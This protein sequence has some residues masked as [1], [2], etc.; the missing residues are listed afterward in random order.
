MAHGA[1]QPTGRPAVVALRGKG[2]P[3]VNSRG[4]Q[5]PSR[6]RDRRR[7]AV[8]GMSKEPA[9][10]RA[11]R[12]PDAPVIEP[13]L[14]WPGLTLDRDGVG[15]PWLRHLPVA[16]SDLADVPELSGTA[17]RGGVAAVAGQPGPR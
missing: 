13:A 8:T 16:R 3:R 4:R 1:G 12:P 7:P 9:G 10:R 6:G 15:L 17:A 11:R 5:R 14:R 2:I